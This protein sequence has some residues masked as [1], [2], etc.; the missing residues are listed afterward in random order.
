[1]AEIIET[2]GQ[3]QIKERVPAGVRIVLFLIGLFPWLAP[4]ELL[5]K[6]GCTG[7][8]IMTVF[9]V[10]IS[11]GAIVVSLFFLAAAIFGM[12]QTLTVD[13]KTRTIIHAFESSIAP[14]HEKKY[15]FEQ[16]KGVE[17]VP[18]EWSDE[19]SSYG[20][21]FTLGDGQNAEPGSFQTLEE[22]NTVRDKIERRTMQ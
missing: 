3:I 18:H 14:L 21:R 15:P 4:V 9:F 6:P 5:L 13:P 17:I 16:L 20:L 12:N 8:S 1:M 7:F 22:A 19:P 2:D 11:L 10:V